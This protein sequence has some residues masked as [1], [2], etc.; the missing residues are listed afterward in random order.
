MP[1][2][3][4]ESLAVVIP[5]YK[6]D[7]LAAALDSL[8]AQTDRG[9]R[10]Y[11]GDDASPHDLA[12]VVQPFADRL[13]L[14]LHRFEENI[15]RR[16]LVAQWNRTIR[17]SDETWVWLF[18]DDDVADPGCV[19][20]WR[21]AL[22]GS[23]PVEVMRFQTRIIDADGREERQ[24][25]P[26]PEFESAAD[27]ILAR[28]LRQRRSYACEVLFTRRAF[29]RLGGLVSFPLAWCSDDASWAALAGPA[30]LRTL[31]GPRVSWRYG[32]GNLSVP[33]PAS[34]AAKREALLRYVEW[35]LNEDHPALAATPAQRAAIRAALPSWFWHQLHVADALVRPSD[36][37]RLAAQLG[38]PCGLRH[39]LGHNLR[40]LAQRIKAQVRP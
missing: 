13:D 8:A 30:G 12:A 40:R 35:L 10:V 14:R 5:A 36:L 28:L 2:P 3:P 1:N 16:D 19:A 21:S 34:R 18:S 25:E 37:R 15:G 33:D 32:G 26:H 39:L 29:D 31:A 4:T 27:F 17:L 6:P 20:A 9:F 24:N 22:G 7:Y 11:I 23:N 38:Q